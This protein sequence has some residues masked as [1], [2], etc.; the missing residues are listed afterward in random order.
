MGYEQKFT[1]L[2][3]TPV[4]SSANGAAT[5]RWYQRERERESCKRGYRGNLQELVE[6]TPRGK[7]GLLNPEWTEWLMG[8]ETGWT[9][10]DV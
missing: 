8:Y 1:E 10:S 7:I 9:E 2:M 4:A 5:D 3:P 6:V